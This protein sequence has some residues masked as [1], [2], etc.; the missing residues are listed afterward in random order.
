[1]LDIYNFFFFFYI[2]NFIRADMHLRTLRCR[3]KNHD[4]KEFRDES[5]LYNRIGD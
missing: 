3:I 4:D 2:Y 1:M 5:R